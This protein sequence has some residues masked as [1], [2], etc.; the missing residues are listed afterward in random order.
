MGIEEG[1]NVYIY[2][3]RSMLTCI[4]IYSYQYIYTY[5]YI[6]V[7]VSSHLWGVYGRRSM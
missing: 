1:K 5:R 4:D 3:R 7:D 2:I 6:C